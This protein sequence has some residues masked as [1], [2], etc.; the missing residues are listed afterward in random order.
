MARPPEFAEVAFP[1]IVAAPLDCTAPLGVAAQCIVLRHF[2][3]MLEQRE[4]AWRAD[5]VEAVH[6][7]R[8]AARRTRTALQTFAVLWGGS[9]EAQRHLKSLSEFADA[10]NS[11]RDLDVMIIYL[12]EQLSK[13]EPSQQPAITWLLTR[14]EALREKQRPQLQRALRKLEKDRVPERFVS[15]FSRKPF[16]LWPPPEVEQPADENLI[17]DQTTT[18]DPDGAQ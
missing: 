17:G 6:R 10:F 7:L 2:H 18:E 8:V 12:S 11:A 15:Y 1:P 4:P 14:N 13:A 3:E 9:N 16:D 5:E